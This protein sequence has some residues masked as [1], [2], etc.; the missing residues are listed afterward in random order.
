[1][2]SGATEQTAVQ[3][4]MQHENLM[5][6]LKQDLDVDYARVERDMELDFIREF[7]T[8]GDLHGLGM[9]DR[10][11]RIRIAI[12]SL[13]LMRAIFRNGPMTYAEAYAKCYGLPLEMRRTARFQPRPIF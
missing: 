9:D 10:R 11:E 7:S 12:Y 5:R 3:I 13:G 2:A 8:G 6:H 4:V 1:V